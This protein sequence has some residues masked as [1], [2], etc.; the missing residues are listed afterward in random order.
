MNRIVQAAWNKRDKLRAEGNKCYAE[1]NK[2]YAERDKLRAERDK[3]RAEGDKCYAEGDKCYAE[4]DKLRAE[5]DIVFLTAVIAAYGNVG[6]AWK[7]FNPEHQS[8]ECH[9][10]NG[11]VYGF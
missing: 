5:G 1:G 10:A 4:G 6:L 9:L 11:E 3:L 8:Y 7:N 2:C